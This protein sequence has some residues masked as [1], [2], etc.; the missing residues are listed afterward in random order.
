MRATKTRALRQRFQIPADA[1]VELLTPLGFQVVHRNPTQLVLYGPRKMKLLRPLTYFSRISLNQHDRDLHLS[2]HFRDDENKPSWTKRALVLPLALTLAMAVPSLLYFSNLPLIA[3]LT[4]IFLVFHVLITIMVAL[5]PPSHMYASEANKALNSF[6]QRIMKQ[7]EITL[8]ISAQS[9][10]A[11]SK[12]TLRCAYCHDDII[13]QTPV[14]CQR[15]QTRL[16]R[17]CWEEIK[18]C[19]TLGCGHS[20]NQ[21]QSLE[22]RR[23]EPSSVPPPRTGLLSLM[24]R[25]NAREKTRLP[26]PSGLFLSPIQRRKCRDCL[27]PIKLGIQCAP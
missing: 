2:A 26:N 7:P 14:S 9:I 11:T 18:R 25:S 10:L 15:C 8:R 19:P 5:L 21:Q 24:I 1:A 12:A 20:P 23:S 3:F 22:R 4:L 27:T 6:L 16:H 17:D 13:T